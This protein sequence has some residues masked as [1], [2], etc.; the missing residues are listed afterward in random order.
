MSKERCEFSSPLDR[1]VG[2]SK[3]VKRIKSQIKE[4]A[5][6]DDPILITGE[7]GTG[8]EVVAEVIHKL[9]HHRGAPFVPVNT[10]ALPGELIA[11]ELFG[12]E[13]GAFTGATERKVGCFEL[14]GEGTLLLDEIGAMPRKVQAVLLRVLDK[15][16]F[17]RVGGKQTLKTRCRVIATTNTNLEAA[18]EKGLFRSD[19]LYRL[20]VYRIEC[21]PMRSRRSDIVPLFEHYLRIFANKL[22]YSA[23]LSLP[24]DVVRLLMKYDWPGNVRELKNVVRRVLIS[25]GDT[26]I[27]PENLPRRVVEPAQYRGVVP[28]PLGTTLQQ[29]EKILIERALGHVDG[30]KSEAAKLLGITRAGLYKKLRRYNISG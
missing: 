4:L 23:P 24:N 1:I 3:W 30:N 28:I 19:L 15:Q 29:A 11:S 14:A 17:R 10:A 26:S 27:T 16:T 6:L 7:T 8:K 2:K 20:D 13:Q 18:A 12:H 21:P 25:C 9:S 22:G 5:D